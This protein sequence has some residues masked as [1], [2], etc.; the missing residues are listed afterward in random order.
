MV[1]QTSALQSTLKKNG[2]SVTS[3]RRLVFN[4]LQNH[5]P[6]TMRTL[7]LACKTEV[8]RA[9]V[10][11]TIALFEELG[12][13]HRLQIGWK[14]K[15]ELSDNFSSHHHHFSCLQCGSIT[16]IAEDSILEARITQFAEK[17]Q[18]L[19]KDHQLE[20]SGL[21]QKCQRLAKT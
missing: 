19:P 5:E 11:R 4:T 2:Y 6:Q 18:F 8:D 17:Y 10:Y 3:A 21:C 1:Q 16:T 15:L 20:I 14:Y 7:V 12:I 13:I 9:S